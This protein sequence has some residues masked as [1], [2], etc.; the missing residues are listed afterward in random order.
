MD[1]LNLLK[2]LFGEDAIR[3][4]LSSGFDSV[5]KIAAATPESLSFFAGIQ[6]S[7]ARQIVQ[8]AE[9]LQSGA[10]ENAGLRE[11]LAGTATAPTQPR[12][13]A[14]PAPKK[15]T[16]KAKPAKV[17][18]LDE[19]PLLDSGPLLKSLARER[20][21]ELLQDEDFLEEVGLSGAE[22]GFLEGISSPWSNAP[23]KERISAVPAE[24]RPDPPPSRGNEIE[25]ASV[26]DWSPDEDPDPVP[27]LVL[28]PEL[29]GDAAEE[30]AEPR[31]TADTPV[32]SVIPP[33][34]VAHAA[35]AAPIKVHSKVTPFVAKVP[36]DSLE[37]PP[38]E[39]DPGTRKRSFWKFG[40]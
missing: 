8:S 13:L 4:I 31:D 32:D 15:E 7:L 35:Q 18:L 40:R 28:A 2:E 21:K 38:K 27:K 14:R 1:P 6:E 34:P 17:E 33:E 20:P 22:A 10:V 37:P 11:A 25:F 36:A 30:I 24:L 12:E 5:A 39:P 19:R 29:G 23:A 9:Q 26:S 16:A 3:K